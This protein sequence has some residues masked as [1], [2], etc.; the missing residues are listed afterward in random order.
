MPSSGNVFIDLELPDAAERQTKVR[1]ALTINRIFEQRRL[2][3]A[4]AARELGTNQPTISALSHYRLDGS[5]AERLL[6]FLNALEHDVEIVIRPKLRSQ[7]PAR[8]VVTAA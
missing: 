1:L 2:T 4:E 8:I 7:R 3:Q 6:L 5:S